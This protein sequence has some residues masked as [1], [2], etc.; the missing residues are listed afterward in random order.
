M[1]Q[2]LETRKFSTIPNRERNPHQKI[3]SSKPR[4]VSQGKNSALSPSSNE[5][6]FEFLRR[7]ANGTSSTLIVNDAVAQTLQSV[8]SFRNMVPGCRTCR[9]CMWGRLAIP[10]V[11]I[12]VENVQNVTLKMFAHQMK[13]ARIIVLARQTRRGEAFREY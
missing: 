1:C 6:S 9:F 4:L 13:V 11:G 2:Y 8:L 5:V 7:P 10:R 3:R 12:N